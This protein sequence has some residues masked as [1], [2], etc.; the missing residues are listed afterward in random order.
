MT[1]RVREFVY[2]FCIR[3]VYSEK[4]QHFKIFRKLITTIMVLE[5][6]LK[7]L[8]NSITYLQQ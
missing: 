8:T 1:T 6:V 7:I 3:T 5:I 2:D 4:Y